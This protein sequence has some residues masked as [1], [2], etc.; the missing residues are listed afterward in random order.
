[1]IEREVTPEMA[2]LLR[3]S[4]PRALAA[5]L[6]RGEHFADAEDAV[7]EAVMVALDSWTLD[8]VPDRPVGWIV[9]VAQRRLIDQ[10][11]RDT[12]RRR[13][14]S[15]VTSWAA[16]PNEPDVSDDDALMLLFL[17]CHES[18]TPSAAIPLTL[19]AVGGLTTREIADALLVPEATIAQ[20]ISRAKSSI[21]RS[22]EPF[23]RPPPDL[24]DVRLPAVMQVIYL[25]FN[26]G[27][28]ATSGSRLIRTDLA[29]EAIRMARQLSERLPEQPEAAGLLAL[30]LL[31]DARR[32]AR[33]GVD[34]DLAPLDKQDRTLWN[35]SMIVEGLNLLTA[36]LLHHEVG[37]YQLQASVAAVHDQASS[38][39]STDWSQLRAIYDQLALRSDNPL[40]LLNRAVVIAHTDGPGAAQ[41]EIAA[42]GDS[43]SEN[44]RYFATL[45]YLHEMAGEQEAAR[46]AY[47]DA[48]RL[49]M[50][51]P[52]RRY[53]Q[54]M[55]IGPNL[56]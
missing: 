22:K 44:H 49:A 9:R 43:L 30:L 26:E 20:R 25:I 16:L 7:Q 42:L 47:G 5:L 23:R 36:A 39:E 18:L 52:E 8:G 55:A 11:H 53:L 38:F 6:R 51:E 28:A 12:A 3:D 35:R 21:T 50:N 10:H 34:G 48:A 27:Y 32:L 45:A 14:E 37:E 4:A 1:V 41:I 15:L 2:M 13:R 46:R 31:T 29:D 17:C 33:I 40:V 19:R 56:D 24:L 54:R